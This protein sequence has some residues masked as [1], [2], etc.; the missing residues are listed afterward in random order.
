MRR[1]M[2]VVLIVCFGERLISEQLVATPKA[3]QE[4]AREKLLSLFAGEWVSR[5]LYVATKLEIAD[6]LQSGPKSVET[7][8]QLTSSNL[9]S[10]Y[11]LL[12]MLAGFGIFEEV[13]SGTFGNTDTSCLL[14]KTHPDTLH[15]LSL[16]FGEDIL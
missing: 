2:F 11:R 9:D 3:S 4:A 16:F 6:H 15:S 12:H 10:L 8:A 1:W 7:L 13:S 14:I 5:S